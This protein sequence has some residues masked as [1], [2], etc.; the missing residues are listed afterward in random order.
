M[1]AIVE[2]SGKQY[3]V[4]AGQQ[5][6]VDLVD[7]EPGATVTLDKVLLIGGD[8]VRVGSPAIAGASVEAKVVKHFL[9]EKKITFKYI[10]RRRFR[11]KVG[12]RASHTTLEIIA[13]H[14]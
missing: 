14:A 7:A 9:G 8:T 10:H 13:I 2:T 4:E 1:Y 11:R 3:R 6:V 5:L 12:Y